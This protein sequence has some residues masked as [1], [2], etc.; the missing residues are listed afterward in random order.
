MNFWNLVQIFLFFL[1][2]VELDIQVNT[3]KDIYLYLW[4]IYKSYFNKLKF[5]SSFLIAFFLRERSVD[6][7]I[8]PANESI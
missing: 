5:T 7:F 2:L 3:K 4:F 8:T 1:D 6:F